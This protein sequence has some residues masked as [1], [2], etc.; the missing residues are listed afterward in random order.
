MAE[1]YNKETQNKWKFI[2]Y[3]WFSTHFS[4][5]HS[6]LFL[7][8]FPICLYMS[9]FLEKKNLKNV[10]NVSISVSGI[11]FNFQSFKVRCKMALAGNF[12]CCFLLTVYYFILHGFD[13]QL[14]GFFPIC[15]LRELNLIFM[16]VLCFLK[17][18]KI[19][20]LYFL[21]NTAFFVL[22]TWY[23]I[24]FFSL[25][26]FPAVPVAYGSSR[27]RYQMQATAATYTTVA[28]T[29]KP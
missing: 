23:A 1:T 20:K 9:L 11:L 22:H 12:S 17:D 4:R 28:A 8:H 7:C 13:I 25:F 27:A 15:F 29:S 24:F 6:L 19:P 5:S 16:H 10:L 18:S 3:R 14:F 26:F 2:F 21:Y